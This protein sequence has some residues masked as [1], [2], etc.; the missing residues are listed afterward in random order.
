MGM[1][2]TIADVNVSVANSFTVLSEIETELYF[3]S[4]SGN[5]DD[6]LSL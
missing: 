3:S 1:W 6:Y 4:N 5:D 2:K